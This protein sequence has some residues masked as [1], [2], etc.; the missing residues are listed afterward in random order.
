[1]RSARSFE[2]PQ[3]VTLVSPEK[4][5]WQR[6]GAGREVRANHRHVTIQSLRA[7]FV[8]MSAMGHW[9]P[10]LDRGAVRTPASVR[11]T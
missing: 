11:R 2:L 10:L 7:T 1:M 9:C 5:T 4:L 6:S 3:Y 8:P